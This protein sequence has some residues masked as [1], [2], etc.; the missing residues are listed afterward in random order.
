MREQTK[1]WFSN[2]FATPQSANVIL[3]LIKNSDGLTTAPT[4]KIYRI[5]E[6]AK[7]ILGGENTF[8]KD[9]TI[10]ES[11]LISNKDGEVGSLKITFEE[12]VKQTDFERTDLKIKITFGER[13]SSI[14]IY[15]YPDRDHI[16]IAG[17][18]NNGNTF[19]KTGLGHAVMG[20]IKNLMFEIA[21]KNPKITQIQLKAE[22]KIARDFY[23]KE[24][25]VKRVI[26]N[27]YYWCYNLK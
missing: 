9:D 14:L 7:Q 6:L 24:G 19:E 12:M 13:K 21:D 22:T 8:E 4:W 26:N 27:G 18:L 11:V 2:L 23:K 15:F 25:F 1:Q 5:S 20:A 16:Y 3:A 17:F 10:L